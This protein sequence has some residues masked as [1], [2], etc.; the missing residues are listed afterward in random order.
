ML[1]AYHCNVFGHVDL[2]IVQNYHLKC[3]SPECLH[4]HGDEAGD[5]V[6]HGQMEYKVVNIRPAPVRTDLELRIVF[7]QQ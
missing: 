5:G 7:I 2:N 4:G 1:P 6:R 3:Q